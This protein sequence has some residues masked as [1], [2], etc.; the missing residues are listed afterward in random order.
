MKFPEHLDDEDMQLFRKELKLAG[1]W[2]DPHWQR[3]QRR[4]YLGCDA[5][6]L[7]YR[8]EGDGWELEKSWKHRNVDGWNF[9]NT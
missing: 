9:L 6:L 5:F 7:K 4:L 3:G 8:R 1:G 2:S